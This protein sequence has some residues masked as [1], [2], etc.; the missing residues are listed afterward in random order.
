V[1]HVELPRHGR[2]QIAL[3]LDFVGDS[4]LRTNLLTKKAL[5]HARPGEVV[6]IVS[7]NLS[8]VETIPFMLANYQCVHL[9]TCRD[10]QTWRIYVRKD[11]DAATSSKEEQKDD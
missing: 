9:H 8:S 11:P 6:E 4:C 5:D 10:A 3:S 7:D 1:K 2:L